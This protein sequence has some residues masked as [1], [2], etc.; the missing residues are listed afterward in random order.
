MGREAEK[1]ARTAKA[2]T[3]IAGRRKALR[4]QMQQEMGRRQQVLSRMMPLTE[5][6]IMEA[7]VTRDI[8][9][10]KARAGP[11]SPLSTGNLRA[12]YASGLPMGTPEWKQAVGISEQPEQIPT[13]D[14]L[15]ALYLMNQMGEGEDISGRLFEQP[16][17]SMGGQ[18][19]A[20]LA[21]YEPNS[22]EWWDAYERLKTVGDTEALPSTNRLRALYAMG[23]EPGSE[24]W[25]RA[26]GGR[27]E[28]EITPEDKLEY[29][30]SV[31]RRAQGPAAY[32]MGPPTD[33]ATVQYA[34]EMINQ[35]VAQMQGQ[36]PPQFAQSETGYQVGQI[37]EVNGAQYRITGFDTDGMPLVEPVNPIQATQ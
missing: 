23:Q 2:H 29:Y 9:V 19:A 31:M 4:G 12:Q 11:P 10:A 3:V 30:Q 28:Q 16:Q 25:Y 1:A 7:D 27:A 32:G 21:Q 13:M 6:D 17:P 36:A 8:A 15:R 18:T 37:I 20:V 33:P 14:R 26:T 35:I 22:P 24:E 34:Q 5:R